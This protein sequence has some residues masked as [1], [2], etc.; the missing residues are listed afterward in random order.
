MSI[1]W[2]LSSMG[3]VSHLDFHSRHQA[4][5]VELASTVNVLVR[6]TMPE[7]G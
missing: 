7:A 3:E 1:V 2:L 6:D 5:P 4:G